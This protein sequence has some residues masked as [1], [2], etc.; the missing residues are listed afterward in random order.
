MGKRRMKVPRRKEK[1]YT[2]DQVER[3]AASLSAKH[4]DVLSLAID[5]PMEHVAEALCIPM[6]TVKSRLNRARAKLE[7]LEREAKQ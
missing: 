4:H 5:R 1:V 3:H 2:L 7:A 6:G